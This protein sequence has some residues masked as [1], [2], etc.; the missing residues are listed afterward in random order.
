[1]QKLLPE[2]RADIDGL[3]AIAILSVILFHAF[4]TFTQ[5]GFVG[6]D[7]FFVISG[8]LITR[9]ILRGLHQGDFSFSTFYFNRA[10]RIFPALLLV[11]SATFIFG[12]F[13]LLP[14]EFG[15][16]GKHIAAGAGFVQN[17]VLWR[18]SG[19]FDTAS[20][21]KPL[22]HL[23][24]LAIEE[25]YYLI[26]PLLIWI[27]SRAGI[28]ILIAL[29]LLGL[30]SFG[31]NLYFLSVD[32]VGSFF[33]PHARFW[34]ILIGGGCACY[35]AGYKLTTDKKLFQKVI[36]GTNFDYS[37]MKNIAAWLGLLLILLSIFGVRRNSQFPGWW[38][39]IPVTGT[40]NLIIAGP[41]AWVNR[42]ILSN[43]W[44]VFVGLI[45][46]PLYLWHWPLLSLAHIFSAQSL[47][48][49]LRVVLILLAFI[50]AW[51]TYQLVERRFR[52]GSNKKFAA[53][54]LTLLMFLL[55]CIGSVTFWMSGL[56]SRDVALRVESFTKSVIR[57]SR[58][59]ECFEI[60]L[61]FE[62]KFGWNCLLGSNS[63]TPTIMAYGDSHALSLIPVLDKYG[64][65]NQVGILF[66]GA[67]GCPPLL[68]IQSLRGEANI[69]LYNCQKLNDR[70]FNFVREKG[71]KRV[72]LIGR[73][74]YYTGGLIRPQEYNPI[75]MD[76]TQ[77]HTLEYARHSF[78]YGLKKTVLDYRQIGV[79]VFLINDTPQQEMGPLQA[80]KLQGLDVNLVNEKSVSWHRHKSDQAWVRS[81][82]QE[83]QLLGA[84]VVSFD[85]L[86]CPNRD[87]C[88]L[89]TVGKSLYYDSDH[90]SVHGALTLYP[91]IA[92]ALGN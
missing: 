68:G 40:I 66:A 36:V 87:I 15:H 10:T 54:N 29:I 41:S 51:L 50:F 20:E 79:Q 63:V 25:Q 14:D 61:A 85:E 37:A 56:P 38:A 78:V 84:K 65:D 7:I 58:E 52:F 57:T 5:G 17:F 33:L 59:H 67:S 91:A 6:V 2:Y 21:L 24:S 74:T 47:T 45:S 3:R 46:Y 70:I 60:P 72:L 13:W 22:L 76:V 62:R 1:M 26:Y 43:K 53:L 71:I 49:E 9:I 34:E 31:I 75:S 88:F 89:E 35:F 73:W 48:S 55:G 83:M 30:I 4:P 69:S 81:C 82:I 80:L 39:L 42:N 32:P 64:L 28:N 77:K 27:L 18:E 8:Y 11:L 86:L 12:W 92:E 19:Y 90:L 16:L 23:W 44:F